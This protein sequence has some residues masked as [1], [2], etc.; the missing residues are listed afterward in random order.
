MKGGEA[1]AERR[2]EKIPW[3]P[4][5]CTVVALG[6]RGDVSPR[7][8]GHCAH[9]LGGLLETP[10]GSTQ[11]NASRRRGRESLFS[12]PIL[13]CFLV[14]LTGPGIRR[15]RSALLAATPGKGFCF[16]KWSKREKL[17]RHW[18]SL[19]FYFRPR[20]HIHPGEP[21]SLSLLLVALVQGCPILTPQED[22]PRSLLT[23]IGSCP[24]WVWPSLDGKA[25]GS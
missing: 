3:P 21:P 5:N 16:I 13:C 10:K 11:C 18:A 22:P 12:P 1:G 4:D 20:E 8:S 25:L 7:P 24:R 17:P 23:Y 19:L 2:G 15:G 14:G 6:E 9:S